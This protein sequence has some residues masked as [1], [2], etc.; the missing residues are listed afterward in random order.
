MLAG[1]YGD[2]GNCQFDVGIGAQILAAQVIDQRWMFA[3][4][5]LPAVLTIF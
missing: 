2:A 1:L 4:Q 3:F 5:I